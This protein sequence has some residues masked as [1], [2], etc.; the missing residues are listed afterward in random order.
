ME[1]AAEAMDNLRWPEILGT[2]AGDNT[3]FLA[4][5]SAADSAKVVEQLRAMIK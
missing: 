4:V 2:L 5:R 1:A 3:I